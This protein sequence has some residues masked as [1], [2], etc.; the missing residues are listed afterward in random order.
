MEGWAG[1]WPELLGAAIGSAA[2]LSIIVTGWRKRGFS[3]APD[4]RTKEIRFRSSEATLWVVVT[5]AFILWIIDL[6]PWEGSSLRT[7]P[8]RSPLTPLI[9]TFFVAFLASRAFFAWRMGGGDILGDRP[10]TTLLMAAVALGLL[11]TGQ[12]AGAWYMLISSVVLTIVF[13]ATG[14]T[15]PRV[16]PD[17][18][19]GSG[20]SSPTSEGGKQ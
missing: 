16:S 1:H 17:G 9:A 7:G 4:E 12:I 5:A 8:W 13:W 3:E 14:Y 10:W 2:A 20:P 15:R 11:F 19:A 18:R 6:R